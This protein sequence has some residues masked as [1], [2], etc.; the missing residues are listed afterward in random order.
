GGHDLE[1]GS[2]EA[3]VDLADQVAGHA[4]GFDD[5]KG[6]LERHEENSPAVVKKCRILPVKSRRRQ[7]LR[8]RKCRFLKGFSDAETFPAAAFA[9]HVGVLEAKRLVQ[10]LFDEVD[11]G[12]V[13]QRQGVRI[14]EH[15]DAAI[16][17]NHVA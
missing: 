12:A 8:M 17:E 5:R 13:D 3:A 11:R 6:A 2:L 10:A 7:S 14:D 9:L 4:I 1:A 15:L 16:L